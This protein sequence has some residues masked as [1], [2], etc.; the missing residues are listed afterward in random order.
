MEAI[1]VLP[2]S[3]WGCGRVIDRAD[4]YCR[5][6]GR[7]QGAKIAW[8]YR[9]WGI[10]LCTLFGLGPFGLILVWRSP[11]LPAWRRWAYTAAVLLMTAYIGQQLYLAWVLF[12]EHFATLSQSLTGSSIF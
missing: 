10:I 6:C 7:G 5:C 11:L 12:T 4:A 9:D 1:P 3:C 8:Y 2:I